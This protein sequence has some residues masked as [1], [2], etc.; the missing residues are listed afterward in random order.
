M[1][2][3][4]AMTVEDAKLIEA[5]GA[6]RIELLSALHEGGITPSYGLIKA[7]VNAVKIPVNIIIR[8]KTQGFYYSN[9]EIE[10]M[11]Q[12]ILIAKELNANGVVLGTLDMSETMIDEHKLKS[13]LTVC[14]GLEVIFARAIDKLKNPVAAMKILDKYPEIKSV[15]TSGGKGFILDNLPIIKE[16]NENAGHLKIRVGGGICFDNFAELIKET[17]TS[18][19]H[20]GSAARENNSLFGDISIAHVE[21]LVE[22]AQSCQ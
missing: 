10:L 3:I 4:I 13:L 20:V 21:R 14:D 11:K 6:D 8:P 17:D 22:I 7:V 19:Y 12:D 18:Y 2:E 16:M 15:T 5:G 1:L 9:D